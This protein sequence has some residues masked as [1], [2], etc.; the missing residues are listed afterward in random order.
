M[1]SDNFGF[2]IRD[3]DAREW[4]VESRVPYSP[5]SGECGPGVE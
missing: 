4:K 5:A 3:E 1:K 2:I